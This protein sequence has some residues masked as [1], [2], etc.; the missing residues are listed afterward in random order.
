MKASF[1][2]TAAGPGAALVLALALTTSTREQDGGMKPMTM[3]K[4]D[5]AMV[6]RITST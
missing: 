4:V 2:T 5:Q 3:I 1:R 6:D